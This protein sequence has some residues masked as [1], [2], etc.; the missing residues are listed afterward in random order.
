MAV[1]S[2]KP[3]SKSASKPVPH[4]EPDSISYVLDTSV[5][6]ADPAALYRFAEHEVILPIAVIGELEAKRDHPELGYFARAETA[7]GHRA[8]EAGKGWDRQHTPKIALSRRAGI[9][10]NLGHV[11]SLARPGTPSRGARR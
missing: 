6:L 5:L 2:K 11:E 8:P 9:R 10:E 7:K 1:T 4:D 3:T